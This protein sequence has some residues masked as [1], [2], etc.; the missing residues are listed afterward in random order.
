MIARRVMASH[1][2]TIRFALAALVAGMAALGAR[3][4]G[5]EHT[6]A[7][8]PPQVDCPAAV[9]RAV[10]LV[11]GVEDALAGAKPDLPGAA[12]KAFE[13]ASIGRGLGRLALGDES[14]ARERVRGINLAGKAIAQAADALHAALDAG[15]ADAAKRAVLTLEP[16]VADLSS[17]L[18]PDPYVCEMRCEGKRTYEHGGICPVCRMALIRQSRAPFAVQVSAESE[19]GT[20]VAG[21]PVALEI[22]LLDGTAEPVGAVEVVHEHPL[23]LIVV[24]DDLSFY[25]HEHPMRMPDGVFHLPGFTFP[26]GGRFVVFADFTPSGDKPVNRIARTEFTVAKG[27]S[28]AHAPLVLKENEDDVVKDGPYEIRI[29]CNAGKFMAGQDSFLRY[30]V[31][32]ENRPVKDLE[33]LMGALGHLVIISADTKRYIHAHPTT[34]RT[35][36]SV[37]TNGQ[38]SDVVFHTQFPEPGMYRAFAQF[39]HRGRIVLSAVTIDAKALPA[40]AAAPTGAVH[41]HK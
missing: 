9:G 33:P 2:T 35:S 37:F 3:G 26:F 27:D 29:R 15:Q 41:Q 28:A 20:I 16:L 4:D 34:E 8:P 22:R 23:H 5:P 1:A 14:V 7:A 10:E 31:D 38:P 40:G 6:H 32:L 13:I 18:P 24:S 25:A 17:S 11:R 30:G 19:Q 12:D 36:A 21:K 39:Q